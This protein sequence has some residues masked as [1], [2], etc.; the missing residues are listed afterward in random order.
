MRSNAPAI[1]FALEPEALEDEEP[2]YTPVE[3][4]G[5]TLVA[6]TEQDEHLPE[7]DEIQPAPIPTLSPDAAEEE[8][9]EVGDNET[10]EPP[11]ILLEEMKLGMKML[12]L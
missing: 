10:E 9:A 6:E 8:I 7:M 3:E 11:F 12:N 5:I 1:V 4:P 2:S